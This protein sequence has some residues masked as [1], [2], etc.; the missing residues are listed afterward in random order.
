M[1]D[2][3][4]ENISRKFKFNKSLARIMGILHEEQHTFLIISR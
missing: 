1:F 3:F 2:L 4:L